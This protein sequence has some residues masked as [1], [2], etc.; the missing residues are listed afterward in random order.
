MG[1]ARAYIHARSRMEHGETKRTHTLCPPLLQATPKIGSEG[2]RVYVTGHKT[3]GVN[4]SH[5]KLHTLSLEANVTCIVKNVFVR[6][7]ARPYDVHI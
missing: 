7:P 1:A 5:T 6:A 3:M 2:T 4:V